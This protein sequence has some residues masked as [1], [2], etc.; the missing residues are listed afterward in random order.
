MDS[1][2]PRWRARESNCA[3]QLRTSKGRNQDYSILDDRATCE[4]NATKD[5]LVGMDWDW[6]F[7]VALQSGY[8]VHKSIESVTTGVYSL[9]CLFCACENDVDESA[10]V[11]VRRK[12][13]NRDFQFR[14]RSERPSPIAWNEG[15]MTSFDVNACIKARQVILMQWSH[16][17]ISRK[18]SWVWIMCFR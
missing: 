3:I 16:V 18:T 13:K 9:V 7:P 15:L 12:R 17:M 4:R 1:S 10:C 8:V 2:V 14:F 5:W 6:L 11:W